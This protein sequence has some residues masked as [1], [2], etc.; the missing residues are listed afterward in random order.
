MYGEEIRFGKLLLKQ[1]VWMCGPSLRKVGQGILKLLIRTDLAH[2]NLVTLTF[3]P[4]P[5]KINRV[6]LLPRVDVWIKF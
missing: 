2:L 4:V 3:Y 1:T 5:P 6:S